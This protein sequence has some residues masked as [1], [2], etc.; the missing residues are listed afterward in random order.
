MTACCLHSLALLSFSLSLSLLRSPVHPPRHQIAQ[1]QSPV[2]TTWSLSRHSLSPLFQFRLD[3]GIPFQKETTCDNPAG[4]SAGFLWPY[5]MTTLRSGYWFHSRT[6]KE[7][8]FYLHRQTEPQWRG[9]WR[10]NPGD[11][12]EGSEGWKDRCK[13]I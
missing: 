6:E 13:I 10:K 11:R 9:L 3:W 4:E 7:G 5:L 8:F 1:S 12:G 2:C